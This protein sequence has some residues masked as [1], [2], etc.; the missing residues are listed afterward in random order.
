[1]NKLIYRYCV[2]ITVLIPLVGQSQEIIFF[3]QKDL[4]Y[5]DESEFEEFKKYLSTA[6]LVLTE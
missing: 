6:P 2:I 3:S 1:M 5:M 4:P